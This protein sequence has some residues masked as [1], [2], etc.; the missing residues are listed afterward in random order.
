MQSPHGTQYSNGESITRTENSTVVTARMS[1][2]TSIGLTIANN[3]A[4]LPMRG[5]LVPE[6]RHVT[7]PSTGCT[8]VL[9]IGLP[10]PTKRPKNF[11]EH[12]R[13]R[14]RIHTRRLLTIITSKD[15]RRRGF[16][17]AARHPACALNVFVIENNRQ[18]TRKLADH[19]VLAER[20][21]IA[22]N[23]A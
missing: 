10:R 22:K 1:K 5:S 17:S 15:S 7:E 11:K 18:G 6:W 4:G 8:E 13:A 21:I 23:P 16:T 9:D 3:K 20:R 12:E 14:R 2:G 19:F